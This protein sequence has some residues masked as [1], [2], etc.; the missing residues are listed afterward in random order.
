MAAV[1][2]WQSVD[3][4]LDV[5]RVPHRDHLPVRGPLYLGMGDAP[6]VESPQPGR[7]AGPSARDLEGQVVK[8]G[9]KLAEAIGRVRAVLGEVEPQPG[10]AAWVSSRLAVDVQGN[11]TS[12]EQPDFSAA[13][14]PSRQASARS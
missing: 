12:V 3:L 6:L 4:D 9:P 14:L 11:V 7:Q 10:S 1:E 8:A 2:L 13:V 5:V